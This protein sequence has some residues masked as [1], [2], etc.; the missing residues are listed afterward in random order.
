MD[1]SSN[2]SSWPVVGHAGAVAMLRRSI[3]QGR[4]SHAYL[5]TGQPGTGKRALALAFAMTLNCEGESPPGQTWP[6]VPCGLC[7]SCSRI[8]RGAHPDVVE[9]NLE[10]QAAAQAEAGGR[11]SGPAKDL[12]IDAIRDLLSGVGLRAHS[13]RWK[14]YIIGDAERL[15]DEASNCML[16]TLEEPPA[17]TILVLL[18]DDET[19]VLPT[20][21][22]RCF[23]VPLRPLLRELV[24]D[25]LV[26][27]RGVEREEA[28]N[29]AALSAGRFG[30]AL[31]LLADRESASKR[32]AA[33]EESSVLS[34][35]PIS[36]RIEA[37][38][39]YAK[40]YT[41]ARPELMSMLDMWEGWWRDVLVV[42]AGNPD[43][44]A[45]A[46]QSSA[47][48]SA[49][50]RTSVKTAWEAINLIQT[51]RKQLQEN[52]NPRL[53]LEALALGLP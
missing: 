6:D 31:G 24:A 5:F 17:G 51:T 30:Y 29:V 23:L 7:P 12:K 45:N 26:L 8:R 28:L 47:L 52:V 1:Y 38:S 21:L 25:S 48:D 15:N 27:M 16:K 18:A 43:L 53:A 41:E 34:H 10:T 33:L 22:S 3:V 14:V 44:A 40:R 13:A 32:R 2:T 37:A 42:K 50:R 11:K 9:A 20:I 46:D 39:R 19:A 49:A 4:L 36:E 35:A